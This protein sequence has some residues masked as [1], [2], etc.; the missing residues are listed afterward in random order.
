MIPTI[1]EANSASAAPQLKMSSLSEAPKGAVASNDREDAKIPKSSF[2]KE[3]TLPKKSLKSDQHKV[4]KAGR[5]VSF[6]PE[7]VTA[8]RPYPRN[9]TGEDSL[10]GETK[11]CD[12]VV[13]FNKRVRI[14]KIRQLEDMTPEQIEA[15]Y[16]TEK[17]LVDIRNGLRTQI[18]SLVEQNFQ[19]DEH[20]D[21]IDDEKIET[22]FCIRG[23]EHEFPR[24]KYRRK[25]LK[26]MSRGAVLEEQRL[27][28]EFFIHSERSESTH[29]TAST[30]GS[31]SM[32]HED[33][34]LAIADVY[35]IESKPAVQLALEYAKRDEFVADQIYFAH[36]AI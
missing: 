8:E 31:Y 1:G 4:Q 18:R 22:S 12:R 36:Q 24:G 14:R 33:P 15:T 13:S 5:K 2:S 6:M 23:L 7:T 3:S 10:E 16:F 11:N 9:N 26:M 35:R 29:D 20:E 27:Q 25:Q 30:I 17:E 28:R 21:C 34:S 32:V 19:E